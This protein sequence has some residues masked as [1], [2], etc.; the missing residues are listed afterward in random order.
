MSTLFTINFIKR[1]IFD[2]KYL[3]IQKNLG[4][5]SLVACPNFDHYIYFS[6][7]Y[8]NM[9]DR[10][11]FNQKDIASENNLLQIFYLM[12]KTKQIIENED[13]CCLSTPYPFRNQSFTPKLDMFF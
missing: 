3:I 6:P 11:L 9:C 7:Y 5:R 12:L 1:L 13:A 4:G 10:Q 2:W 8:R